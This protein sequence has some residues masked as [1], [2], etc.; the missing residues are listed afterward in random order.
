MTTD[1]VFKHLQKKGID[2][3]F[4]ILRP[5]TRSSSGEAVFMMP[6]ETGNITQWA[7]LPINYALTK[8]QALIGFCFPDGSIRSDVDIL[9][10]VDGPILPTCVAFYKEST[11][12]AKRKKLALEDYTVVLDIH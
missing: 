11:P 12:A 1:D 5:V 9:M 10:S 2:P 4:V 8:K 3:R 6:I 7:T